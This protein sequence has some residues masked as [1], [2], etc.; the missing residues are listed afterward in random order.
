[1]KICNDGTQA[2]DYARK[3]LRLSRGQD[4]SRSVTQGTCGRHQ[5]CGRPS[6][7]KEPHPPS[8]G[9]QEQ[10]AAHCSQS[11]RDDAAP[12]RDTAVHQLDGGAF[13]EGRSF[14]KLGRLENVAALAPVDPAVSQVRTILPVLI[15]PQPPEADVRCVCR[16][17]GFRESHACGGLCAPCDIVFHVATQVCK[18][19][20]TC[21][22]V[23]CMVTDTGHHTSR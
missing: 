4:C 18:D 15:T 9:G 21:I 13:R 3:K 10:D 17:C 8:E 20:C 16:R 23:Y 5:L 14:H 6:L 11:E 7:E 1:M 12:V 19:L 22:A 2:G